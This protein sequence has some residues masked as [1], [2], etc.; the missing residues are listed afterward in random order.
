[1]TDDIEIGTKV[2]LGDVIATVEHTG[3][4]V[5][6][7]NDGTKT[8]GLEWIDGTGKVVKLDLGVEEFAKL[9]RVER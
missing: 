3:M 8:V 9:D 2:K 7:R 1:M 5:D 4:F 6:G